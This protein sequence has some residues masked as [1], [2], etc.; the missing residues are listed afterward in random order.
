MD[1]LR[2]QRTR[3]AEANRAYREAASLDERIARKLA[4]DRLR[5]EL[6]RMEDYAEW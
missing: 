2:E 1:T 3:V 4:Y 5:A 6:E